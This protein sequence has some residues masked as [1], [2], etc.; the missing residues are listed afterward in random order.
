METKRSCFLISEDGTHDPIP[1]PHDE[2]ITLGRGPATKITDKRCSRNQVELTANMI[3]MEVKLKAV[4]ANRVGYNSCAVE[5]NSIITLKHGDKVELLLG[6]FKSRVQFTPP[7]VDSNENTSVRKRTLNSDDDISA[8]KKL[9]EK[10]TGSEYEEKR[11][12]N[13][14]KT[15]PT[16]EDKWESIDQ[17]K[18]LIYTSTGV[19]GKSKIAAYDID[20]TIITTKSGRVFPLDANDW[21]IAFSEVP[22][23]LKKLVNKDY[24]IVFFT[25]QFGIG[26]GKVKVSDY[27]HK[28]KEIIA[29]LD[30]PVQ[31]FVSTGE[32]MY[33]KPLPGMWRELIQE[34]ND[35]VEVDMSE[36]FFCGDAAGREENWAPRKKKDFS[37]SD[38]LFAINIGLTFFT[39][40]EHFLGLPPGR[41]KLPDFNPRALN[42]DEPICDPPEASITSDKQEVVL[43]VGFQGSGK[44]FFATTYLVPKG[45]A[46][47]NRDE[48]GS[49]QKCTSAL[50]NTLVKGQSAVIDNTNP[51]KES[52]KRFI[53]VAKKYNI[54]CRCFILTTTIQQAKHN[55]KLRM[56]TSIMVSTISCHSWEPVFD[57]RYHIARDLRMAGR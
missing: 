20:G 43:L 22:K 33:R 39:P 29:I 24:K 15:E 31:V 12:T 47:I 25:N 16:M 10:A 38:R 26:K 56:S 36:S 48:L 37:C 5:R 2:V 57:C 55:N 42:F 21:K 53:E 13:A 44:T 4:G 27:K 11:Y 9:C 54:P 40:E 32:G 30:V 34:K 28:V 18:L 23:K 45:Y 8:S 52:R 46:H 41:F 17:G 1:L 3:K 51:D 50:E 35:G 14:L 6:Q 49:W 7:P 19:K